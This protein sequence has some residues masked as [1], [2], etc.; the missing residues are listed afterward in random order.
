MEEEI[1]EYNHTWDGLN[2]K[3]AGF[4]SWMTLKAKINFTEK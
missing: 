1:E 3:S 4:G 2:I